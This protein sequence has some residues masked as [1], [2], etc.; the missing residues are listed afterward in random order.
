MKTIKYILPIA[1]F[2]FAT[3][4][5][6]AQ[7]IET[8]KLQLPEIILEKGGPI[9]VSTLTDSTTEEIQSSLSS[10]FQKEVFRGLNAESIAFNQ[11]LTDFNPWMRTNLYSTTENIDEATYVISGD[12]MFTTNQSKSYNEKTAAESA[13]SIP[14]VYYEFEERST[15]NVTGRVII[16]DT[17]TN[18]EVANI[19]FSKVLNDEDKKTMQ[20]A[21]AKDPHNF[22]AALSD[23]FVKAFKYRFSAVKSTYKYDFPKI[24]PKN[25]DLRK[26][27]RQYKRDLKDLADAGKLKELYTM[28]LEIQQKEDSPEVNECIGMCYEIV[29]NYTQAKTYY[30]K[31]DS[32]TSKNRIVEQINI[33]KRLLDFGFTINEPEI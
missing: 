14:F 27:F 3:S 32:Q 24:K 16:T 5:L 11:K 33:Q 19:P 26:E 2:V 7:D 9:Y 21:S 12:Y 23:D 18:S 17:E 13:D 30:D 25:K 29:G 15:A 22:I 20:Q 1:L 28:Y 10:T 8:Y 6:L 31:C 4:L